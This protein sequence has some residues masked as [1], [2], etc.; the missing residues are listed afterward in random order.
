MDASLLSAN[1]EKLNQQPE[2]NSKKCRLIVRNLPF[3][4]NNLLLLCN[5][6]ELTFL[7]LNMSNVFVLLN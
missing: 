5:S 4:V 6:I 1:R 7:L 2:T 3:R